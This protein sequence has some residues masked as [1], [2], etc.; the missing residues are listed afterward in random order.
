[1]LLYGM[2]ISLVQKVIKSQKFKS[3]KAMNPFLLHHVTNR[4][5]GQSPIRINHFWTGLPREFMGPR[6]NYKWG[7]L[8]ITDIISSVIINWILSWLLYFQ[9][10]CSIRVFRSLDNVAGPPPGAPSKM[11]PRANCPSFPP[12]SAALLLDTYTYT[13]TAD[14]ILQTTE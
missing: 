12:L 7:P 8:H 2:E 6:A 5:Q 13:I 3:G 10:D 4:L 1:M 14:I 9:G 11:R